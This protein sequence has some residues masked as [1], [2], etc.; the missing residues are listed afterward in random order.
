MPKHDEPYRCSCRNI[1]VDA[2]A[3]RVS[4]KDDAAIRAFHVDPPS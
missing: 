2:D 3:G 1:V 4:V